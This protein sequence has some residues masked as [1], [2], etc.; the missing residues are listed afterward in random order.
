MNITGSDLFGDHY[1]TEEFDSGGRNLSENITF[2]GSGDASA[3]SQMLQELNNF[4]ASAGG[5]VPAK[6]NFIVSYCT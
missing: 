4:T 1:C 5:T 2:T 6:G 3:C